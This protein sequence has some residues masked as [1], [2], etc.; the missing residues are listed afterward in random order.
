VLFIVVWSVLTMTREFTWSGLLLVLLIP[1]AAVVAV[2][3]LVMRLRTER[4]LTVGRIAQYQTLRNLLTMTAGREVTAW[5][6]NVVFLPLVGG[7]GVVRVDRD[8]LTDATWDRRADAT[9]VGE[10]F[11]LETNSPQV[12]HDFTT[13]TPLADATTEVAPLARP[14]SSSFWSP[15]SWWRDLR[16]EWTVSRSGVTVPSDAELDTLLTQLRTATT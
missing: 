2:S 14:A 6:H 3:M 8:E 15:R 4:R 11:W 7:R 13:V 1:P 5:E 12:A 16:T 9:V 10:R